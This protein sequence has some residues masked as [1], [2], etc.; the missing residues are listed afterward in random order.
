[1]EVADV[2]ADGTAGGS[3]YAVASVS[4]TFGPGETR[5]VVTVRVAGDTAGEADETFFIDFQSL[6]VVAGVRGRGTVLNDDGTG[7]RGK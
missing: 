1:M 5:K 6:D 4:V 7:G 2:R 3:D